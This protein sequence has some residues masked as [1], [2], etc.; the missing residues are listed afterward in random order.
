[1]ILLQRCGSGGRAL[2]NGAQTVACG[3]IS[4]AP[5]RP[6]AFAAMQQQAD[7]IPCAGMLCDLHPA[8]TKS[9]VTSMRSS[10]EASLTEQNL[11][12][13]LH[14]TV[15]TLV[16]REE[17]DLT[18]RQLAVF[19]SVYLDDGPHTVRGL[20]RELNVCKPSISRALDRLG[21]FDLVRRKV[22]PTDRRSVFLLPTPAGG[23]FLAG[24]R[25]AMGAAPSSGAAPAASAAE[26]A[27]R[28]WAMGRR[29]E[30]A[31]LRDA[32]SMPAGRRGG[33]AFDAA[34]PQWWFR[35]GPA[36]R[37]RTD[38]V[39]PADGAAEDRSASGP[40]GP[41]RRRADA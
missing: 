9:R 29:A 40:A 32:P 41:S 15:L 38:G 24:L 13:Q 21:E 1:V 3:R 8:E 39:P 19:L 12:P 30:D 16:R 28:R 36:L 27:E 35:G 11:L 6:P 22:D 31:P 17:P 34:A 5:R 2:N 33:A 18:A 25:A 7:V 10:S 26:I 14:R 37:L 20:A 4:A 23:A